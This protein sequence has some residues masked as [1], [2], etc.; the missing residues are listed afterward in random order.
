MTHLHS[1]GRIVPIIHI[2]GRKSELCNN[3]IK[4][5]SRVAFS[6]FLCFLFIRFENRYENTS[7]I[8]SVSM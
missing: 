6:F 5:F 8:I 1:I 4:Y 3:F 7:Y 2:L